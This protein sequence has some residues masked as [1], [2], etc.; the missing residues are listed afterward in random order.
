MMKKTILEN[1]ADKW[2]VRVCGRW[3]LIK[4]VPLLTKE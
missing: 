3:H 2:A 4:V 1:E